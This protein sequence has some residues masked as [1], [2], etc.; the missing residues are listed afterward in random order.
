MGM[1]EIPSA[2]RV[3][4]GIF[5]RANAGKS[6]IINAIT[7]QD[8]AIIS[9]KKGTTTDPVTKAMELLPLGP[10][11]L[12]DTPGLDDTGYLEKLRVEKTRKVLNKVDIAV[13]AVDAKT[14]DEASLRT[15]EGPLMRQF[16]EKKLPYV[17]A[18]NKADLMT[19]AEQ[20]KLAAFFGKGPHLLFVSAKTGQNIRELKECIAGAMPQ[21]DGS[22][23]LIGDLLKPNDTVVL[24]VP[25]DSAAPKGRLILPQQQVIRDCLEAGAIPVVTRD[26]ELPRALLALSEKPKAVITDSQV[27]KQAAG[28]TPKDVF[29]TSFSI[30]FSRYK[31]DLWQQVKGAERIGSL[32]DGDTVLISEGCTHHRQCGDIGTEQLPRL[33]RG[34]TGKKLD[35]CFT[36]GGDF[37]EDLSGAALVV[38][39]GGCTLNRREMKYRL[40][41]AYAQGVPM[42]NYGTALAFLNGILG[43]SLEL[44]Q[45]PQEGL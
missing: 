29:L 10:V 13:L 19:A 23:R 24:V 45:Q 12:I 22:K 16:A 21:E 44:F 28:V 26:T 33:I 38:H 43:R 6:S 8:L 1:N 31:G 34:F 4:I 32:K 37:P 20:D 27:F 2:N 41:L 7:G 17:V 9:G 18:V 36:S 11:V 40:A 5:G 39:C 3:Q 35:F 42:T 30:L 25:I 14:A 15:I